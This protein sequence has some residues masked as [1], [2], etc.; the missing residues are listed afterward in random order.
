L[1]LGGKWGCTGG[2]RKR[3][4]HKRLRILE[5]TR[6]KRAT[7]KPKDDVS[8]K[9]NMVSL[10]WHMI[11]LCITQKQLFKIRF[12]FLVNNSNGLVAT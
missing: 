4:K 1:G 12:L 9:Q 8:D 3:A 7:K 5:Y 10:I 11:Y 6:S 2:V